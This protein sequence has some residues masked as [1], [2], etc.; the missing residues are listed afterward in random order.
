MAKLKHDEKFTL[1]LASSDDVDNA[2]A[3]IIAGMDASRLQDVEY[4][5]E[6][7]H[8]DGRIFHVHIK[9]VKDKPMLKTTN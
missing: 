5:A 7:Y 6:L 3:K 4:N 8:P 2:F 9:E 1:R